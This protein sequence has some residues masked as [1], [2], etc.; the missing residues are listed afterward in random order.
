MTLRNLLLV[1]TATLGS[2]GALAE[3]KH[4]DD[5]TK[6]VTKAGVAYNEDL[7]FS[8]SIGLDEARMINARV[9]A[10]GEEWRLGGSWLLPMGIVN[11]NFSRSEYDNDA[12]K[13]NYSIGAFIPLS[14][15]DIEPFGWQIFPMAGYSYNDGEVAVFDDDNVGSDYVL[16]PSSTH[17]GYIGAFGLKT[18]TDEWSIMGFGGGSMGSDD[19]SGY[20]AG[21]GASYKLSDAQSFNFFTIFA[22][23]DFGENNSVGASYT[24]EFK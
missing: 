7:Q 24:Y 6:I 20:W 22:E 3:E 2:M 17:G 8:G 18:I 10:D 14:Y 13:N 23:D 12:Y 19:Y 21:V 11:F 1:A 5:P 16:M 4:P 15:F 9:N